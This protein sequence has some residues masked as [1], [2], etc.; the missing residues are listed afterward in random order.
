VRPRADGDRFGQAPLPRDDRDAAV[1]VDGDEHRLAGDA[2]VVF[3]AAL[4][5]PRGAR[6]VPS[7]RASVDLICLLAR[8][9]RGATGQPR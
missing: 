8:D 4:G 9:S 5:I 7:E 3:T 1:A 2:C 6:W